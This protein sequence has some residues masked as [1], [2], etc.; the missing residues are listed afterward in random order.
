VAVKKDLVFAGLGGYIFFG[1][2]FL[3]ETLLNIF[4][5]LFLMSYKIFNGGALLLMFYEY[6]T[7]TVYTDR[8]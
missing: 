6:I 4:W 7:Y 8:G 1:A 2:S 5:R 3:E